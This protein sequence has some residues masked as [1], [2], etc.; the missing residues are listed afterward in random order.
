MASG[1]PLMF[2]T[3]KVPTRLI[4]SEPS[5]VQQKQKL[6]TDS[7]QHFYEDING[8]RKSVSAHHSVLD[9]VSGFRQMKKSAFTN[10]AGHP[11]APSSTTHHSPPYHVFKHI[12]EK[13]IEDELKKKASRSLVPRLPVVSNSAKIH[14]PS[15]VSNSAAKIY[16]PSAVSNSAAKI[17]SPSPSN[18]M[19]RTLQPRAFP[20]ASEKDRTV[21]G[22]MMKDVDSQHMDKTLSKALQPDAKKTVE[23]WLESAN[24]KDRA[25]AIEFFS[26][27]AGS[28]LMGVRDGKPADC[29]ICDGT[30]LKQVLDALY[31]GQK[32]AI[33][34]PRDTK[35][36][37]FTRRQPRL[38]LLSPRTR[39]NKE[40]HK[41]WHHLPVFT[42]KAPVSN[43][44]GMFTRPH[45]A[46]PRHFTIHPEWE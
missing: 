2:M 9:A 43:T 14:T 21:L 7:N 30:R 45:R 1:S 12:R 40:E 26:S 23:K 36:G 41:T 16:P 20:A 18:S 33:K 32:A 19:K 46:I 35:L 8:A 3:W 22:K 34:V 27:L 29:N 15:V 28:K 44:I 31:N 38:R 39:A 42:N 24:E 10:I 11:T 4:I 37:H 25:V 6:I 5:Y 13:D 17:H